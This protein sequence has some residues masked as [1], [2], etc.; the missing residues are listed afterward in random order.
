MAPSSTKNNLERED[1][2]RDTA[3]NKAMHGKS[4]QARGG[5]AA[6]F[7]KGGDAKKAAVDEYFKHWDNKPAADETPEQ[8]SGPPG[9]V[10]AVPAVAAADLLESRFGWMIT[11]VF[12]CVAWVFFRAADFTTAI[13]LGA[14]HVRVGSAIFGHRG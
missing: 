14:T 9:Q 4:A 11:Y 2:S 6:M 7:A 3:F 12:V 1:H 8:A 13:A 5:I 10:E